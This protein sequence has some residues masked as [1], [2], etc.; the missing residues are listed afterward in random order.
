MSE[1]NFKSMVRMQKQFS[2]LYTNNGG[3]GLV[4]I[5]NEYVQIEEEAFASLCFDVLGTFELRI[6]GGHA[7]DDASSCNYI[8]LRVMYQGIDFH[9]LASSPE[10]DAV[11]FPMTDAIEYAQAARHISWVPNPHD[12]EFWGVVLSHLVHLLHG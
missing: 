2:K 8:Q 6:V 5:S 3:G 7:A 1:K 11:G 12:P 4:G 9:S 10:W